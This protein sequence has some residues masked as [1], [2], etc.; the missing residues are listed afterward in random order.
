VSGGRLIVNPGSVGLPAYEDDTP[1]YHVMETG[2]T[3]ARYAILE[4]V[5]GRWVAELVA[6]PYDYLLAAD[7]A[8]KNNRPDWE[9]ALRT[10]S[11]QNQPD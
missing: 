4:R 9:I 6:V 3:H 11:M 5:Q 7:Q 10:G 1:E 2:A 8:R